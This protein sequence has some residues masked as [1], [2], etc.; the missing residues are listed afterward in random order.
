MYGGTTPNGNYGINV[1][2]DV[3]VNQTSDGTSLND[4]WSELLTLFDIENNERT[5]IVNLISYWHTETASIVPQSI[6]APDFEEA[7]ELGIPKGANSPANALRLGFTFRDFDLANRF[8]WKFLRSAS[9][10]QVRAVI[11]S[12]VYADRK[13]VTGTILHRLFNPN[14]ERNEWGHT[15]YGLWNGTDGLAPLPHLGR[16]FDASET[17]YHATET[18]RLDSLDVEMAFQQITRKGYG[19]KESSSQLLIL[20]NPDQADDIQ[21]WRAGKASRPAETGEDAEDVPVSKFDF[22]PSIDAPPYLQE[23]N[24]IG[25]P[26]PAKFGGLPVLGSYGPAYLIQS[27]F[28]PADYVA[29]VATN[30]PS[31]LMNAIGV[32]QHENAA[33][34][35]LRQIS[36]RGPYPIVES[37][38]QRS[39]GVGTRHRSAAVCLQVVDSSNYTAPPKGAFGLTS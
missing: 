33:Y 8:S 21:G 5:A 37:F 3:L 34:Q 27:N 10:E 35:G 9:A 32:R 38:S 14:P 13:R 26:A 2:G 20:A 23:E 7:S 1:E 30:G 29:I 18:T 15:C 11:D 31:S 25:Q 19:T 39:F 4:L 28:V 16:E 22:I 12:I 6:S 24:I 36:G 17:H